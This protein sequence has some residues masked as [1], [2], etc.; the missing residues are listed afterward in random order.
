MNQKSITGCLLGTAIGDA[1]GLPYEGLSKQRQNKLFP[2]R[3]NHNFLFNKGMISDDT[4]HT[5]MVAQSLIVSAGNTS[6]FTKQLAFRL[7]WW[8]LGLPAGIGYATLKSIIK[9]WLGFSPHKSGVFSAGNGAAMRSAIIGVCYGNDVQKLRELVRASTRLTHTDIK[10]EYGALAV[11]LA[12]ST[13]SQQLLISPQIYYKKL[14]NLI[15]SEQVEFLWLI[16]QACDSAESQ[17]TTQSFAAK[18]GSSKG[19]TGYIYHTVPVV[20]QAWLKYQQDYQTAI[21][22]I[23]ACGGDT[24]TTAAILGG[25]VGAAVGK[26]GIP[27]QWLDN[28]WEYPRNIKWMESLGIRLAEVCQRHTKQSSLPLPVYGIFLRNILFLLIVI[29]HGFRRLFPP[30]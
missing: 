25:I 30:Y 24:D 18:I 4:E 1:F 15:G 14:K 21:L 16:K 26:D 13:A 8:L 6:I 17:E 29:F 20:I 10:A 28:L 12:A 11:A 19:I 22:E 27:Q 7:R 2:N 5:C 3:K 23:V 9:L